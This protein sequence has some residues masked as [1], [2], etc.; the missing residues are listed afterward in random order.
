MR[1]LILSLA[2]ATLFFFAAVAGLGRAAVQPG[3]VFIC[4]GFTGC[5]FGGR[6]LDV[7]H[8]TCDGDFIKGPFRCTAFYPSGSGVPS[9]TRVYPHAQCLLYS[10]HFT[11]TEY[12]YTQT[13]ASDATMIEQQRPDGLSI[14]VY[15]RPNRL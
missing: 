9:E 10:S 5:Y 3:G 7:G 11:G 6:L 12:V 14:S 4:D 1:R 8:G 13:Y 2:V 15:C